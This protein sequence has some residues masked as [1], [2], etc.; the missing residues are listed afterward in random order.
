M[1]I[2][3]PA[4]GKQNKIVICFHLHTFTPSQDLRCQ[5]Y[6]TADFD[7]TKLHKGL[8][9]I[10]KSLQNDLSSQITDHM[11]HMLSVLVSYRRQNSRDLFG[12]SKYNAAPEVLRVNYSAGQ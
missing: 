3:L 6:R 8:N 10:L 4:P 1:F 12:S 7:R 9:S 2:T 11:K 5:T